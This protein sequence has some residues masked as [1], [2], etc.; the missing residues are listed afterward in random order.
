MHTRLSHTLWERSMVL[1]T[2]ILSPDLFPQSLTQVEEPTTL[3]KEYQ[4]LLFW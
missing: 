2:Y 3:L 1:R 4:S